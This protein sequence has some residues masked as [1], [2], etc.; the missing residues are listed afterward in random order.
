MMPEDPQ[1]LVLLVASEIQ[2]AFRLHELRG[3]TGSERVK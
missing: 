3:Y 1:H 2:R